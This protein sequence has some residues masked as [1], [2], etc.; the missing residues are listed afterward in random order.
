M[1]IIS[2]DILTIGDEI[3]YGQV[4]DT[5]SAW[6]GT[7]LAKIGI[8]VRQITSVSDNPEHILQALAEIR[9]HSSLILVTGGLGPTKDDLT[10]HTLC[11][12][13]HTEL[14]M[15]EPSLAHVTALF[16]ARGRELT[17]L[18]RQQALLPAACTPISNPVGT[19]P[20]M[21]F[22]QEG[23]VLVSM[24]GVP[25]EMKLI[26][27]ESVLPKLQQRFGAVPISHRVI[28]TIGIGESF[29]AE[30]LEDWENSLPE[31]LK[32]AYLPYLAG[33]RLRLTG[34]DNGSGDL[35]AQLDAE[36]ARLLALIPDYVYG[37][38]EVS[39]EEAVGDLLRQKGFT[40]ATAE[41]CTGGHVAHKIT[42]VA[43]SSEYF[44]GSI[45]AYHNHIKIKQL[46]VSPE[47]LAAYGAVSEEV[48]SQMAANVRRLLNT[49]IGLAT[50]GIAG[51]GGGSPDKPV[52]TI[53]IAYADAE[54][55]L[56]RKISYDKGRELNIAYTTF[57]VLN[58][59]RQQIGKN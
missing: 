22:E 52:G 16:R 9:P 1:N 38:G 44:M 25:F 24:P 13:F 14:V 57:Q 18:N 39:L 32:L 4:V 2:A 41:S 35:E 7:E 47:D 53:W 46:E 26:M 17:E 51:P 36:Q 54:K 3:L 5:N 28:Q 45:L 48:V 15:H 20:A 12:Y 30:Q 56:A 49:D 50:S 34:L 42:S 33:V 8:K 29:L 58:L 21:W 59:L 19:A 23:K 31:N 55:T 37:L 6:L 10:K 40:L 43:G 27:T 11:R